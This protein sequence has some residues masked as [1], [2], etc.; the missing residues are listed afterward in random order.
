MYANYKPEY[1]QLSLLAG[2][3]P[4]RGLSKEEAAQFLGGNFLRLF[5]EVAP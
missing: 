2:A 5:R 4:R 3:L 1:R